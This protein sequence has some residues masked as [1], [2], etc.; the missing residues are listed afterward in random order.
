M[1]AIAETASV[2]SSVTLTVVLFQPFAFGR[3]LTVAFVSGGSTS[4]AAGASAKMVPPD[5]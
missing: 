1:P 3:G 5:S 4:V 2:A